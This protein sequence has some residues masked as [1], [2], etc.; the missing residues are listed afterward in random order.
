MIVISIKPFFCLNLLWRLRFNYQEE[1]VLISLTGLTPPHLWACSKQ[2]PGFLFCVH[3]FEV[4]DDCSFCCLGSFLTR[5]TRRVSLVEQEL[6][7]LPKHMSSP[8]VLSGVRF[9]RFSVYYYVDRCSF[10]PFSLAIVFLRF[11]DSYYPIDISK[12]FLMTIPGS[13]FINKIDINSL[14]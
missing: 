4:R 11:P 6:L 9:A 1:R 12:I 2:G 10:C 7:T 3:W 8:P 14:L 13:T 5:V